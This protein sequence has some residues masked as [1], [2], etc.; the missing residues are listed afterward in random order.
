MDVAKRQLKI[1]LSVWWINYFI[2]IF[3]KC[4]YL[5]WSIYT[6]KI[7]FYYYYCCVIC[8]R[9]KNAHRLNQGC[10]TFSGWG[11]KKMKK[12]N[13]KGQRSVWMLEHAHIA[14][15]CHSDVTMMS[16]CDLVTNSATSQLHC[17]DVDMS[18]LCDVTLW[19]ICESH[20]DQISS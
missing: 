7:Q 13:V 19:P 15:W 17:S 12:D 5:Y 10:T 8:S 18:Y 2:K 3:L 20:C 6:L 16:H 9:I 1:N 4:K 14:L 11:A